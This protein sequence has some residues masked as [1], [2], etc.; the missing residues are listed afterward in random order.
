MITGVEQFKCGSCGV[1]TYKVYGKEDRPLYK[2]YVECTGCKNISAIEIQFQP[3]IAI[4][5]VEGDGTALCIY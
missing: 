4:R 3:T 5:H 2:L 1:D